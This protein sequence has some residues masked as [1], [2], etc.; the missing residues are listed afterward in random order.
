MIPVVWLNFN[1][2]A[3]N[4]GYWDQALLDQLLS[5]ALWSTATTREMESHDSM[6]SDID[7]AVVVVPGRQNAE[8]YHLVQEAILPLKWV[9]LIVTG[10]E[11]GAFPIE[12]IDHPNMRKWVM[13]PQPRH[14]GMS[15]ELGSGMPPN[16]KPAICDKT[17]DW[18]FAGQITHER[19]EQCAGVLRSMAGGELIE[20]PGFTQGLGQVEYWDRL[21]RAKVAP[22]PGGPISPDSFR[23]FEALEAGCIPVADA[24]SGRRDS[25]NPHYWYRI[26]GEPFF[27]VVGDWAEFPEVL[28][29]L[30]T[31]W[32]HNANRV[33]SK[34]QGYKRDLAHTLDRDVSDLS[35]VRRA[36]VPITVLVPTSPIHSHPSTAVIEE[37]IRSVRDQM[38]YAE[39]IVMCDGVRSEQAEKKSDYEE[40]VRRLTWL[41]NHEWENV[42]PLVFDEHLHQGVMTRRA[43]D[44]VRT[45]QI[46]FVEHDTPIFGNIPWGGL[47]E[48]VN[49][50][51][52]NMIRLHHEASIL[53]SHTHLMLSETP[54]LVAGVPMYPAVQWSQR[55]HLASADFYRWMTKTYFGMNSRTM[56]ED[57]MYSV[58]ETHYREEGREGWE[59]FKLYIYAP[60]G[61]MKRSTHLDGRGDDPKYSM[62]F[63]YD[64]QLPTCAWAPFA[65]VRE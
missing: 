64:A 61:D 37:T 42:L 40:Y 9:L 53:P 63:D 48:A 39:I 30:L 65:G 36:D 56:I 16:M 41:C 11:E 32:P 47:I 18:F 57:V 35:R 27:P 26:F 20:T 4:R 17:L 13:T 6:P 44:L 15:V 51:V 54:E 24:Y 45:P 46:L 19:R 7:G 59:R 23:L 21:A 43:L 49:S 22:C 25:G 5:G 62:K 38:P 8:N 14:S 58:L 50:G 33:A 3:P 28:N 55:P 10:D 34:W 1:Y 31:G 12:A 29:G 52:A 2:D 60:E